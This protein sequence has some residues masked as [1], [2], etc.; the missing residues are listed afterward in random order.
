MRYTISCNTP[1][2]TPDPPPSTTTV[3]LHHHRFPAD[4]PQPHVHPSTPSFPYAT[5]TREATP[6]PTTPPTPRYPTS[7]LA[8]VPH[9]TIPHTTCSSPRLPT[10]FPSWSTTRRR[11]TQVEMEIALT[12]APRERRV[13]KRR[14]ANQCYGDLKSQTRT[15]TWDFLNDTDVTEKVR[16]PRSP[17]HKQIHS[18]H[19]LPD[20]LLLV[21]PRPPVQSTHPPGDCHYLWSSPEPPSSPGSRAQAPRGR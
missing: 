19:A 4:H 15:R 1:S 3:P 10:R 13:G 9:H 18:A 5:T 16:N 12:S 21:H 2:P 17:K 14:D 8:P 20:G 6:P 11:S 7:A